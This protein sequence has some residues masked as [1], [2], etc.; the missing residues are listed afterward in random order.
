MKLLLFILIQVFANIIQAITGFAGG[1]LAMPPSMA[2]VGVVP[3]KSSLSLIFL[4]ATAVV[5][6]QNRRYINPK[7][8][9]TMLFFMA[10]GF[11]PG[12]WLFAHM[13]ATLIMIIY[14]VV[15]TLI[16]VWKLWKP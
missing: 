3:A 2:L 9:G 13:E 10:F 4:V 11:L 6:I 16:G 1:P 15:V 8:L 12:L 7:K 14:G 5:A